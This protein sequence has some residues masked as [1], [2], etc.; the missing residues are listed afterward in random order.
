M[1]ITPAILSQLPLSEIISVV[2]YKRDEITTDL[3]CC[4]VEV[5]GRVWTFH[6]EADGW[7]TLVRHL[8]ALPGFRNDWHEAVVRLPF[9]TSETVAFDRQQLPPFANIR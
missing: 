2:F 6:E 1:T 3:I 7:Q 9:E 8:S 4:D 5:R